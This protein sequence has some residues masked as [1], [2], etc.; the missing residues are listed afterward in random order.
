MGRV[1]RPVG[2]VVAVAEAAVLAAQ[3]AGLREAL[4]DQRRDRGSRV[5]VGDHDVQLKTVGAGRRVQRLQAGRDQ[6]GGAVGDDD[7][8]E[9]GGR[10]KLAGR[11]EVGVRAGA[12][13][14]TRATAPRPVF[15]RTDG[16]QEPGD[17]S[18]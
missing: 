4:G 14:H 11:R 13:G 9:V 3:H 8:R 15:L 7:H 16:A 12:H 17:R 2:D 18:R 10:R 1:D 6:L 5:V